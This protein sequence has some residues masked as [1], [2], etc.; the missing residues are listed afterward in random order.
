MSGRNARLNIKSCILSEDK[1]TWKCCD[2]C[3]EKPH[4][5]LSPAGFLTPLHQRQLH[6]DALL[7]CPLAGFFISIQFPF[8]SSCLE[9]SSLVGQRCSF[10]GE[11]LDTSALFS[12]VNSG[13]VTMAM[14]LACSWYILL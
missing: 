6:P 8:F 12:N 10:P 13:D 7:I 11:A 5:R 2:Y 3:V 1:I 4:R 9:R 14:I